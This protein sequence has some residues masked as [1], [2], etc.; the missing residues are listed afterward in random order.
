MF[1]QI[2]KYDYLKSIFKMY[3]SIEHWKYGK[4]VKMFEQTTNNPCTHPV[5]KGFLIPESIS[6]KLQ[7]ILKSVSNLL[8]K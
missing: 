4:F 3:F 2:N 1:P 7:C 6:D 8:L 5:G